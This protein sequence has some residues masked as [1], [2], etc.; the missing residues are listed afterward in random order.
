MFHYL[1]VH[2]TGTEETTFVLWRRLVSSTRPPHILS[3]TECL[4][5]KIKLIT[6]IFVSAPNRRDSEFQT[7]TENTGLSNIWPFLSDPN[8]SR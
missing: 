3:K 1:M 8:S 2:E 7:Q 6:W 5:L 4:C